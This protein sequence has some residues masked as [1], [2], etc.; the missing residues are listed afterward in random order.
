MEHTAPEEQGLL[1]SALA[2][3]PDA[4][5]GPGLRVSGGHVATPHPPV[6]DKDGNVIVAY[7]PTR[8]ICTTP[9][10]S[11][12]RPSQLQREAQVDTTP[13]SATRRPVELSP[14]PGARIRTSRP[15]ARNS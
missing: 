12:R 6:E 14:S 3:G 4:G 11:S 15:T 13:L 1:P 5:A 8:L 2:G 7:T 10:A 9:C